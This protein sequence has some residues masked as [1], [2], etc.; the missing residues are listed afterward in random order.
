MLKTDKNI[1]L[2]EKL[3]P[4]CEGTPWELNFYYCDDLSVRSDAPR[5]A[6]E[7]YLPESPWSDDDELTFKVQTISYGALCYLEIKQVTNKL[8]EA[9]HLIQAFGN[10]AAAFDYSLRLG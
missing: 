8:Q 10:A 9:M 7:I 1:H 2:L 3:A 6:P 4:H 5:F